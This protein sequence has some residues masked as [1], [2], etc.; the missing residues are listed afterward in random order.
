MGGC[1]IP[2]DMWDQL[3]FPCTLPLLHD[4][5]KWY[6]LKK[7]H[8]CV[9]CHAKHSAQWKERNALRCVSVYLCINGVEGYGE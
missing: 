8:I 5:P 9:F 4:F 3:S 7:C 1:D 2:P 6:G